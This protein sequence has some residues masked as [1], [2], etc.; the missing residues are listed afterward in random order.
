[1]DLQRTIGGTTEAIRLLTLGLDRQST[2]LGKIDDLRVDIGKIETQLNGLSNSL[3]GIEGRV[4]R[5]RS[6]II[7]AGAIIAF[8]VIAASIGAQF[9][10]NPWDNGP[11]H[12]E[13]RAADS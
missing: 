10:P 6:W 13:Q 7:G 5:I 9:V 2:Q 3:S 4:D 12:Q 8:I 11:Q 1:M